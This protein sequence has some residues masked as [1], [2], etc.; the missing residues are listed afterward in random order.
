MVFQ[1]NTFFICTRASLPSMC[2]KFFGTAD[3]M[4]LT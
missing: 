1:F 4:A 3:V 2:L